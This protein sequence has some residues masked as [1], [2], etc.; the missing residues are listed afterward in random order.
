MLKFS[1]YPLVI[2]SFSP[3]T[4]TAVGLVPLVKLQILYWQDLHWVPFHLISSWTSALF[5]LPYYTGTISPTLFRRE[6][7]SWG[8]FY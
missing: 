8:L 7:R 1:N 5:T 2:T 4:F 3:I 6:L